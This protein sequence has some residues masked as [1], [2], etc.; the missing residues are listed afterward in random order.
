MQEILL[1]NC[2]I[3]AIYDNQAKRSFKHADVNTIISLLGAPSDKQWSKEIQAN[4][5][6]FVMFKKSFEE[7]ISPEVF[8]D[9]ESQSGFKKYPE[10]ERKENETY[11]LHKANQFELYSGPR[12][13]PVAR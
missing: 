11:R 8:I 4:E 6:K 9:L 12:A 5:P 3:L 1:K 10:G 7:I 2:P 13:K